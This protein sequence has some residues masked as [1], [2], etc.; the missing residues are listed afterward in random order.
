MKSKKSNLAGWLLL[1]FVGVALAV[2]LFRRSERARRAL[3][4]GLVVLGCVGVLRYAGRTA[5]NNSQVEHR[6]YVLLNLVRQDP[7][8]T[9][10]DRMY[11]EG[12]VTADADA[13]SAGQQPM[14]ARPKTVRRLEEIR[15]RYRFD[16]PPIT[17][18]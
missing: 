11:L 3:V 12:V 6:A 8:G 14:S 18:P 17:A 13:W 4:G 7:N 2:H 1:P 10:A 16:L 15:R 5:E 9:A